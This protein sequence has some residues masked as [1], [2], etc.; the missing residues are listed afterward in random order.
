MSL[1]DKEEAEGSEMVRAERARLQPLRGRR[2][3]WVFTQR[4]F[5]RCAVSENNAGLWLEH[6]R[7][8]EWGAKGQGR[9]FL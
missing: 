9:C 3:G 4:S 8:S 5:R 1:W 2:C 7:C 6:L